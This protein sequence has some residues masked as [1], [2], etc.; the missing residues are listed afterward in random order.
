MEQENIRIGIETFFQ[1]IFTTNANRQYQN[2]TITHINIPQ[3]S[4]VT[5][6]PIIFPTHIIQVDSDD[7]QS[8]WLPDP[9]YY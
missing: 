5:Q 3:T 4:K 1:G 8:S 6:P 9:L 2:S 7:Q